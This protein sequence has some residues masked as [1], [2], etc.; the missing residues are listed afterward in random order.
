[1]KNELTPHHVWPVVALGLIALGLWHIG[2]ARKI[3]RGGL[4][5]GRQIVAGAKPLN[6]KPDALNTVNL[7]TDLG[8][9]V[10]EPSGIYTYNL[11]A[12]RDFPQID[13]TMAGST[14][15]GNYNSSVGSNIKP[16]SV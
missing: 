1:M 14:A 10:G 13:P 7:T 6:D 4:D 15:G 2:P 8:P 3:V 16:A 11:I 12:D 5:L 9:N